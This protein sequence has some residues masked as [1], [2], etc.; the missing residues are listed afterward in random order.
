MK[1]KYFL[2][3]LSS[4]VS[5][6]RAGCSTYIVLGSAD[7]MYFVNLK[8]NSTQSDEFERLYTEFNSC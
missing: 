1:K 2:N 4:D 7:T 6:D 3:F 8:E 5:L